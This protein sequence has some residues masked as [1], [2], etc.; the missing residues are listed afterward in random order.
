MFFVQ[1]GAF[2]SQELA[3][4]M[5]ARL[6]LLGVDSAIKSQTAG[7][8]TVNRVLVGPFTN[9]EKAQKIINQLSDGQIN[10]ALIRI[11]K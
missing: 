7:N 10:A 5:K 6:A 2:A 8:N 1:A 4:D 11:T 9:E 3:A